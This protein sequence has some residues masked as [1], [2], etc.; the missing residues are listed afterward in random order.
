MPSERD[1]LEEMGLPPLGHNRPPADDDATKALK[2]ADELVANA[3]RWARERPEIVD[4]E[5]ASACQVSIDL[6]RLAESDLK[7]ARDAELAPFEAMVAAIKIKFKDPLALVDLS[8]RTLLRKSAVWLVRERE[9]VA[10]EADEKRRQAEAARQAANEAI[11]RAVT[12]RTMQAELDAQRASEAAQRAADVAQRP[13]ERA[14]IK[15]EMAPR[16]MTLHSN[17]KAEV[18]DPSLA[19]K[20]YGRNADVRAAALAKALQLAGR[21]ARESK[22]ADAAPPGFRFYNDE[23]AQ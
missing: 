17:W 5:Q 3:N 4:A 13:V 9:R 14:R 8:L 15:G 23:R 1:G 18:I 11:T 7:A 10:R 19:L 2:R 22:R 6:L 21:L 12:E 20:H 16:A